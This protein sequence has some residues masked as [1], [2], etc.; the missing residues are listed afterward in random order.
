M[1]VG[2]QRSKAISVLQQHA[3]ELRKRGVEGMY[4]FGSMA[5]GEEELS[6]DIDIFFDYVQDG[7]FSMFDIMDVHQYVE[8]VLGAKADVV[9]RNSLHRRIKDKVIKEAIRIF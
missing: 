1:I 5:R 3:N 7:H 4:L 8:D 6:S 9:P 2:M